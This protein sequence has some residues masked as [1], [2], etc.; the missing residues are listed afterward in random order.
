MLAKVR[1]Q[2]W[3]M[4]SVISYALAEIA[5]GVDEP[6]VMSCKESVMLLFHSFPSLRLVAAI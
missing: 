5:K 6:T 2:F 3:R 4:C 1:Q